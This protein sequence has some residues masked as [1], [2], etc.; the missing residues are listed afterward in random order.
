M[1]KIRLW[2]RWRIAILLDWLRPDWCWAELAMWG[3]GH[4]D[5]FSD[6]NLKQ[7]CDKS[8]AYCGKCQKKIEQ[9]RG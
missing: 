5:K 3:L 6:I 7:I 4:T 9:E 2:F 8:N 1:N